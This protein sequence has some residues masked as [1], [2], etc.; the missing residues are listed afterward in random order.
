M[1]NKELSGEFKVAFGAEILRLIQLTDR[2]PANSPT[3]LIILP[4]A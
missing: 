4:G 3:E 1:L 2:S